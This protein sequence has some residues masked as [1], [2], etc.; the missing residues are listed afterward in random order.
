MNALWHDVRHGLRLLSKSKAFTIVAIL[1]L[2]LGI[3]ANTAIFS[4]LNALFFRQLPVRAP[5]RL[6]VLTTVSRNGEHNRFSVPLFRELEQEQNVFSGLYGWWGDA[7]FNVEANGSFSRDDVWAVTGLFYSELGTTPAAGRLIAPEDVQLGQGVPKTVAVIG[8][9][10]WQRAY[11]R[12]PSVIGK[13]IRI[14]GVPFEI[15]GVAK[16][17]FTGTGIATE[18]DVT[19]PLTAQPAITDGNFARLNDVRWNGLEIGGRLRENIS[20]EQAQAQL[21]A[22]W[23]GLM[24]GP[25][26]SAYTEKER[27][28]LAAARPQVKSAAR[29]VDSDL[30]EQFSRPLYVMMGATGLILLIACVNLANLMLG[31]AEA[32]RHE[33]AV[34]RALGANSWRILRQLLTESLLLSVL[35]AVLGLAFAFWSTLWL[36]HFITQL[37]LVPVA[38]NVNPDSRVLVF[39]TAVTVF[40]GVLFGLAPGFQATRREI[41]GLQQ[42]SRIP[43][44]RSGKTGRALIAAQVALSMILLS[45]AGLFVRT[46]NKLRSVDTGFRS[47]GVLV[48]KLSPVPAGYK[49]IDND[50]YYPE[51]VRRISVLPGVRAAG[52]ANIQPA[53]GAEWTQAVSA[54]PSSG[55]DETLSAGLAVVSPGFFKTLGISLI[56]GRDVEWSDDDHR[57]RVAVLSRRLAQRLFH[58]DDPISKRIRIGTDPARQEI[59]VVGVVSDARLANVRTP[60]SLSVY[61]PFLQEPKYIH[62]NSLEILTERDPLAMSNTV[63]HEI[64]SLGHEYPS[65]MLTLQDVRDRSLLQERSL[66]ILASFFGILALV[67]AAIG[68]YGLVSYSVTRRTREIG[69][70]MALGVTRTKIFW[71]TLSSTILLIGMGL[72]IG[73]PGALAV[74]RLLAHLLFEV[75]PWD[76][77]TLATV[78]AMLVVI[79]LI[80]GGLPARRASSIDPMTALREE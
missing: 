69:L 35:G 73:I 53:A 24:T 57:P 62:S 59:Q 31:R 37:Y 46:V 66:A 56:E 63:R 61:V 67:L 71:A 29:G 77:T 7:I 36:T 78:I 47:N 2:A 42:S 23:L 15:I 52:I 14:E 6:T 41:S 32:R 68:L 30:R 28:A 80:A 5:D 51:L 50:T 18:P 22:L 43:G 10:L 74:S 75:S 19:I 3:G 11:D 49:N 79:A 70:K 13:T 58:S 54:L 33:I 4:L 60:D 8:Y 1:S 72:L 16:K 64:E 21:G 17:G 38:L 34:R 25:L 26:T 27:A 65:R 48:V 20:P 9:S 76:L 40:A 55:G 44:R 12:D 39:T 45:G